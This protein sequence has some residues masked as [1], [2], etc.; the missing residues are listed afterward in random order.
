VGGMHFKVRSTGWKPVKCTQVLIV[1]IVTIIIFI[2][3]VR[4]HVLPNSPTGDARGLA[5]FQ[6]QIAYPCAKFK[7]RKM[8]FLCSSVL[9]G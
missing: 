4:K 6:S 1:D 5:A 3:E 9:Y 2:V 7:E 8:L